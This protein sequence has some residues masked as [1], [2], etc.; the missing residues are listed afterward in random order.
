MTAWNHLANAQHI[1][2][3]LEQVVLNPVEWSQ[4]WHTAHE[5]WFTDSDAITKSLNIAYSQL[6]N[7]NLIWDSL[8]QECRLVISDNWGRPVSRIRVALDVVRYYTGSLAIWDSASKYITMTDKKLK[9]C[10]LN[11]EPAAILMLPGI[12]VNR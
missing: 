7:R 10:V 1:D 8:W 5:S 2:R 11:K 9:E 4:A 3:A 6:S 12:L